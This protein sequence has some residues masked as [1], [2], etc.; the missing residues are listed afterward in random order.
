MNHQE[1]LIKFVSEIED[2]VFF[3][4]QKGFLTFCNEGWE[5]ITCFSK[6]ELFSKNWIDLF[7][8][9]DLEQATELSKSLH[10]SKKLDLFVLRIITNNSAVRYVQF[11]SSAIF[12]NNKYIGSRFIARDVSLREFSNNFRKAEHDL[13][14]EIALGSTHSQL[15]ESVGNYLTNLYE[16][17]FVDHSNT[18]FVFLSFEINPEKKKFPHIYSTIDSSLI[19]KLNNVIN[20]LFQE[21]QIIDLKK[22]TNIK[23]VLSSLTKKHHLEIGFYNINNKY[24]ELVG[25][26]VFLGYSDDVIDVLF[27]SIQDVGRL[28]TLSQ[29]Q[30][31]MSKIRIQRKRKLES[32]VHLRTKELEEEIIVKEEKERLL[33]LSEEYFRKTFEDALHGIAILNPSYRIEDVNQSFAKITGY[34]RDELFEKKFTELIVKDFLKEDLKMLDELL[35][36]DLPGFEREEKYIHKSQKDIWVLSSITLMKDAQGNILNILLQIIDITGKKEAEEEILQAKNNAEKLNA[37]KTEF[38]ANMSHEIRSPLN[39]IIGFSHVVK[40]L[41]NKNDSV[42]KIT[43]YMN[44]IELS[45]NNLASI[46]NDILDLSKIEAGK[47]ELSEDWFNPEQVVKNAYNICKAQAVEKELFY[48]YEIPST[49]PA[50]L[51]GD[52]TK[53]TQVLLNLIGNAIKF[54][55]NK[56]NVV[57]KVEM[58]KLNLILSVV[59]QGIGIDQKNIDAIFNPFE[60]VDSSTTRTH[61]GTGLGLSITKS[62][63]ELMKG[64]IS[65]SSKV[66]EGSTFKV[67]FPFKQKGRKSTKEL[68]QDIDYTALIKDVKILIVDDNEINHEVLKGVFEDFEISLFHAY[69]G[70]ECIEITQ[71]E[72]PDLILMDFHM[73]DIDGTEVTK[74]LKKVFSTASIPILGVSADAFKSSKKLALDSGMVGYI[75]KPIDFDLLFSLMVKYLPKSKE[76]KIEEIV[77]DPTIN[78]AS[79]E[80]ID[81]CISA[82]KNHEIYE[83][84]KLMK[85]VSEIDS[86]FVTEGLNSLLKISAELKDAVLSGD[87]GNLQAL[88][89]KIKKAIR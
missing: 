13:M 69:N 77:K 3:I 1:E 26:T 62:L 22:L 85:L 27:D 10:E 64:E 28:L 35:K 73:P 67:S 6:S 42:E 78:A 24:D 49:L 7:H 71:Q 89:L 68:N 36:G 60:Q 55:E 15:N 25:L 12:K 70:F 44:N 61:G 50:E 33:Q 54:T 18:G 51:F 80:K 88:I 32:L 84:E 11:F 83:T 45:S 14:Q 57:V 74:R 20:D 76:V 79:K 65:V 31:R 41:I 86:I 58:D 87:E 5:E 4:D 9:D 48:N 34:K 46:I 75:T 30:A 56:K 39:A 47:H 40:N 8:K 17:Q 82:V 29:E 21:A 52:N 43:K 2:G 38:L 59:D 66:N 16:S 72:M 63:V 23:S 53:L 19:N 37:S 81:S